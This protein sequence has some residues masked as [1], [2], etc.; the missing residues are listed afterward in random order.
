M[1]E[2]QVDE[3]GSGVGTE[4]AVDA[5]QMELDGLGAQE[6]GGSDLAVDFAGGDQPARRL[7]QLGPHIVLN[8]NIGAVLSSTE[9]LVILVGRAPAF[10]ESV[11]FVT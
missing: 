8:M 9:C 4:L 6:Q 2:E 3:L 1:L 7:L 5:A 10:C 11:V